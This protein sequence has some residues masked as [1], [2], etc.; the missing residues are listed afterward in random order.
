MQLVTEDKIHMH[1]WNG[2]NYFLWIYMKF[3][4]IKHYFYIF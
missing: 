1:S 2:T 3:R 4:N